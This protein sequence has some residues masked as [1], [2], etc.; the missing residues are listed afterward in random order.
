MA[1]DPHKPKPPFPAPF[2]NEED[3]PENIVYVNE[4]DIDDPFEL[5]IPSCS[6][7]TRDSTQPESFEMRRPFRIG[8]GDVG[9]PGIGRLVPGSQEGGMLVGPEHPGFWRPSTGQS[10]IQPGFLPP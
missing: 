5:P 3:P 2:I 8:E 10:S 7:M 1:F 4:E 6:T 9:Q